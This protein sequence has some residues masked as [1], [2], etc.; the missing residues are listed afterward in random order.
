MEKKTFYSLDPETNETIQIEAVKDLHGLWKS[1]CF[2]CGSK[3]TMTIHP[4]S[5]YCYCSKCEVIATVNISNSDFTQEYPAI[6]I[7]KCH[8]KNYHGIGLIPFPALDKR[9]LVSWKD[10]TTGEPIQPTPEDYKK[11]E[12]EYT[13]NNVWVL[14]G[15]NRIALDPDGPLAEEFVQSL[16]LPDCPISKSGGKSRHRFF[17]T[18][19]PIEFLK[20]KFG[21]GDFLEVRT[22]PLGMLVPPSIHPVTKNTYQWEKDHSPWDISFPEFPKEAYETI[23][24]RVPA[25]KMLKPCDEDKESDF[26]KLDVEKYLTEYGIEYSI[27]T[28]GNRMLYCLRQCLFTSEH[29]HGDVPGDAAITQELSGK[30]GYHCF[31]NSCFDKT[32]KEARQ[33]ISGDQPIFQFCEGYVPLS[34][35]SNLGACDETSTIPKSG[36]HFTLIKASDIVNTKEI[37]KEWIWEGILPAGGLSLVVAKPKVGKTTL[38]LQLAVAVSRGDIFLG[39]KTR[40][41][42]VVYLALEEHRDEVQK[43]LSKLGVT[44]EPLY[45]HFGPAPARAMEEVEPLIKET[46]AKFLVIDIL[47]KFCRVKDLNDY[48]QVT[49]TLEP[50]MAVG[51]RLDCQISL[52]HHAGKKD[53]E[54]GDDILGSTGLLGGVDT[55][56]HIK[57]RNTDSRVFSTIQRYGTDIPPTVIALK[58]G[59][60]VMEGSREEVEIHETMPLILEALGGGP[61]TEKEVGEQVERNRNLISKALRKLVEQKGIERA[62]SGKRGDPFRYSLLLYSHI[63]EESNREMKVEPNPLESGKNSSIDDF[64]KN[65]PPNREFNREIPIEKQAKEDPQKRDEKDPTQGGLY[66]VL[67]D[68]QLTY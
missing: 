66:E 52:T 5:N 67:D 20:V 41:A 6:E 42:N 7:F 49:R 56:I 35:E 21:D 37:E 25:P 10:E 8:W 22:G 68:G 13:Y 2:K 30:L 17:R 4:D 3:K 28:K 15:P 54:D 12:K 26:R 55:S 18:D 11:W 61:L 45:I 27:K 46:G 57:K 1:V 64:Q 33:I 9:P 63:Y 51:R 14:L 38:A 16:N 39:R 31:H 29:G 50:L 23:K 43:N 24:S 40:Q 34:E 58:D 59:C 32:W 47:Q 36:H 48:S 65:E 53:R 62:G 19:E 44:D 60:L